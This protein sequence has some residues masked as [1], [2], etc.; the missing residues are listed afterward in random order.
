MRIRL[1][2]LATECSSEVIEEC[3]IDEGFLSFC[4]HNRVQKGF[5]PM[6]R[7]S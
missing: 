4:Y 6:N 3:L 1:P 2:S 5:V 7:C